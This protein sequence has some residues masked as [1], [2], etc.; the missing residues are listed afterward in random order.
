[1]ALRMTAG[2][3]GVSNSSMQRLDPAGWVAGLMGPAMAGV[4]GAQRAR[5]VAAL[6]AARL[7]PDSLRVPEVALRELF[8]PGAVAR[9]FTGWSYLAPQRA[10]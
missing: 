9:P 2:T 6:N 1:M 10:S 4:Q 3:V 8:R 5:V 7:V